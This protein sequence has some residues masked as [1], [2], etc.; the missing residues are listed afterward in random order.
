LRSLNLQLRV[1]DGEIYVFEIHPRFSGTTPIRAGAGF[2][3][4][5]VLLRHHLCG[6]S[7]G[8]LGY[9]ENLAAIRAC[10][11]VLVPLDRMCGAS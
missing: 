10:E 8:R 11:Q 9:R 4:P 5:D 3:E 2:N 7:F 1:H 6:E